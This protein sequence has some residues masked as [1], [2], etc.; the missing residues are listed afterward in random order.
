V[1]SSLRD[2]RCGLQQL[3][4]ARFFADEDEREQRRSSEAVLP[5]SRR[6]TVR[7]LWI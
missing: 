5:T 4:P 2:V 7:G 6:R 3:P 1:F